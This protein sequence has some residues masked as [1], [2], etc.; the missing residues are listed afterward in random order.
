MKQRFQSTLKQTTSFTPQQQQAV[1]I[2]QLNSTALA[3]EIQQELDVNPFLE[4]LDIAEELPSINAEH[5]QTEGILDSQPNR[6]IALDVPQYAQDGQVT[7]SIYHGRVLGQMQDSYSQK[8]R[9]IESIS[10]ASPSLQTYLH[11][12]AHGTPLSEREHYVLALLIDCIEDNGYL[13]STFEEIQQFADYDGTLNLKELELALSQ[14]Q[15][16]EPSGVGCRS[17]S[18]CLLIQLGS[19][20]PQRIEVSHAKTI[21]SKHLDLLANNNRSSLCK[22]LGTNEL[23]LH[24]SIDLIQT[25]DPSPGRQIQSATTIYIS[26]DVLV[27]NHN[28]QW[29]ASLNNENRP[30]LS[31]SS[32]TQTWIEQVNNHKAKAPLLNQVQRAKVLISHVENRYQTTLRVAAEIVRIQQDYF[33]HGAIA[34]KPLT[35]KQ[36]AD[37]LG[38]HIST[39]SRTVNGKYML[40][41]HGLTE[42]KFFFSAAL[43]Q[44]N[45]ESSSSVGIQQQIKNMIAKEPASKPISDNQIAKT[46]ND[47]GI[48]VARRTVAKYREQLNIPAS[49]MRKHLSNP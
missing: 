39:I 26:A 16:L 15:D 12:Q 22:K 14:L 10:T 3:Q 19:F 23:D 38:L 17:L 25:L 5:N 28:G 31:L 11:E 35:L 6:D 4:Q 42:L 36:V 27:S 9:D 46:L 8:T 2:L 34:L 48:N 24:K 49:S 40:S 20:D 7:S 29:V 41:K 44:Q 47:K 13:G 18:E 21:V 32:Y 33:E 43:L 1:K 30:Q 37:Q 45:G